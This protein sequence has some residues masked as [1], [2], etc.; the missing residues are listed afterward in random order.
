ME[1]LVQAERLHGCRDEEHEGIEVSSPSSF[2]G[3]GGIADHS[4]VGVEVG[5]GGG[6]EKLLQSSSTHYTHLYTKYTYTNSHTRT[7]MHTH[8]WIHMYYT[9]HT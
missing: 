1:V 2:S 8:K 4:P 9:A 3:V 5:W 7:L 6:G